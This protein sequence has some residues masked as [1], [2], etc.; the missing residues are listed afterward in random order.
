MASKENKG[1]ILRNSQ[2]EQDNRVKGKS[3]DPGHYQGVQ[4]TGDEHKRELGNDVQ[5]NDGL[6][7]GK[8][9]EELE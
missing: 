1:G 6:P 3:D 4:D 5:R 9:E 7:A 8:P 2:V